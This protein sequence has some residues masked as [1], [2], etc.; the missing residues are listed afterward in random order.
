M[1]KSALL[2]YVNNR[3]C[4]I[5]GLGVSNL[6]LANFLADNGISL[7]IRDK[8]TVDELGDG[9][10]T[11]MGL[12]A[13]F[14]TGDGC[15]ENLEGELIF[16]SPGLRPDLSGLIDARARHAELTSEME[17]LLSLT[18]APTFAVTG[19]DGK[20]T[21]TTL[22]GMF[23]DAEYKRKGTGNVFVGGNIGEPLLYKL[24]SISADDCVVAELSSFQLM[25]VKKAPSYAAITNIS[26]N[27]LD[28]H[29]GMDEYI[30]AKKNII[31]GNTKRLV[32]NGDCTPTLEIASELSKRE[33]RPNIYIF[34]SKKSRFEDIFTFGAGEND[35]ALYVKDGYIIISDGKKE[36]PILEISKIRVPGIHNIENFMTAIGLTYGFTDASVYSSVA[37]S[38]CGVSHRLELIRTLDGVDY[39]NS[40]IDSSP[41]RTAAAISALAGRDIVIICGGYDKKIPYEPLAPVLCKNVRAAVLTGATGKKIEKAILECDEYAKGAPELVYIPDF[42][43]A[44]KEARKLA[45]EG[46]CVLLSPASASFDAFPNFAVRGDTFR[47]IVKD[48]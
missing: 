8:K 24:D 46:G 41:T 48:F 10:R 43:G 26:P 23:L 18:D 45:S 36:T 47:K 15:F 31:G 35:R 6:P 32:T 4:D 38:F 20:T 29:R 13:S 19:S 3:K 9:A 42:E 14:V 21:S 22:T 40:S 16:R 30:A 33:R 27:H 2:D 17:L 39:Y 28:W 37:D 11:L 1:K 5:L 25:T 7:C 34:S 12:G 44:V